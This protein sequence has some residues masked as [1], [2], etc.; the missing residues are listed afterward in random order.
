MFG[1]GGQSNCSPLPDHDETQNQDH[2]GDQ[3]QSSSAPSMLVFGIS[4]LI[5]F[6]SLRIDETTV[7]QALNG[8]HSNL[9]DSIKPFLYILPVI[10]FINFILVI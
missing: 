5:Q 7:S 9:L 1:H 2:T 6:C 10:F 4:Y 3:S 8:F